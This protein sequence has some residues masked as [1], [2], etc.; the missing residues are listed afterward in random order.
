[1]E[2]AINTAEKEN[3]ELVLGG[4]Q[5]YNPE[6]QQTDILQLDRKIVIDTPKS[7]SENLVNFIWFTA[8]FGRL[9]GADL[10]RKTDLSSNTKLVR[11]H[12]IILTLD[13]IEK[14]RRSVILPDMFY[15]HYLNEGSGSAMPDKRNVNSTT[16]QYEKCIEVYKKRA[17]A[18]EEQ[19]T[20]FNN[21]VCENLLRDLLLAIEELNKCEINSDCVYIY[22]GYLD[23][24][25]FTDLLINYATKTY[26]AY[27]IQ[28]MTALLRKRE[29]LMKYAD[30][31]QRKQL[32]KIF[33]ILEKEIKKLTA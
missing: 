19:R 11:A 24:P 4:E 6:S 29:S 5:Y 25:V 26:K 17:A 33:G 32:D 16:M 10:L 31:E 13:A 2:V 30:E 18:G 3:A 23:K 27:F 1:L 21:M 12:D 8:W 15:R 14:S 9:F 7:Y 22:I 28:T 20:F